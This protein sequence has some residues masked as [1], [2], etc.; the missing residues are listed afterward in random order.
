MPDCFSNNP[1]GRVPRACPWI[2]ARFGGRAVL[3]LLLIFLLF[4]SCSK[5]EPDAV[6]SGGDRG[7]EAV[8]K[9]NAGIILKDVDGESVPF[10]IFRGKIVLLNF[11]VTWK[12]DSADFIEIMNGIQRKF[13][14]N[15]E[16]VSVS[17]D[18]GGAQV[19]RSY[20]QR[21]PINHR[22]FMDGEKVAN[23]FGGARHLPTTYIVLR[24][25]HVFKRIDGLK[26][27]SMYEDLL[28]KLL[29]HRM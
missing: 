6:S 3:S 23:K 20:M 22:I 1:K 5:D 29:S 25:G 15:V 19:L 12:K 13:G 28:V 10:G 7:R 24:D 4:G 16:V 18:R 17:M 2:S 14:K 21:V 27:K 11:W 9:G 8:S 26:K